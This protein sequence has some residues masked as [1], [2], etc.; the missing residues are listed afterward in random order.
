MPG[1]S[2]GVSVKGLDDGINH[3]RH[4][5]E[6]TLPVLPSWT[7]SQVSQKFV[8]KFLDTFSRQARDVAQLG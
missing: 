7:H 2:I 3:F 6:A 8:P 4:L 1:W 5:A